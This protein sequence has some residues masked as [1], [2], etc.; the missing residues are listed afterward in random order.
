MVVVLDEKQ[1]ADLQFLQKQSEEIILQFVKISLDF[2]R[3]G[4]NPKL[5]TGA[6]SK[7]K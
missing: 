7:K 1:K 4:A 2:I 6:A 5:Y 3:S